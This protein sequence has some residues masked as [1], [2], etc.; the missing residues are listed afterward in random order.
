MQRHII[1]YYEDIF[2]LF[3]VYTLYFCQLFISEFINLFYAPFSLVLQGL[4][5]FKNAK[6][7]SSFMSKL[8]TKDAE[9]YRASLSRHSEWHTKERAQSPLPPCPISFFAA[10]DVRRTY[11]GFCVLLHHFAKHFFHF[12]HHTI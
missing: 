6:T 9:Q 3:I 7:H 4:T 2:Y 10:V 11:G 1:G 5:D 12:F 8:D